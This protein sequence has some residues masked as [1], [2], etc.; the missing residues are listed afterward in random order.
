MMGIEWSVIC[1]IFN[2]NI[3]GNK[4]KFS[5]IKIAIF[6]S[7]LLTACENIPNGYNKN[8]WR[9]L[10]SQNPHKAQVLEWVAKCPKRA[11]VREILN[12]NMSTNDNPHGVDDLVV[13]IG[14]IC[15]KNGKD[16]RTVTNIIIKGALDSF[17]DDLGSISDAIKNKQSNAIPMDI[18]S[19]EIVKMEIAEMERQKG[20]F[21]R[22]IQ[23]EQRILAELNRIGK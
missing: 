20:K 7:M 16:F 4:M 8:E 13:Y 14:D 3:R 23:I 19:R 17:N 18:K 1:R 15:M 11:K 6:M 22:D 2:Q 12:K 9:S 5:K 10:E 21:E